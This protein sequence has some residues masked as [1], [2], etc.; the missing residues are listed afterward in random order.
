VGGVTALLHR[1]ERAILLLQDLPLPGTG[2]LKLRAGEQQQRTL[3]GAHKG[4]IE[5]VV[6]IKDHHK[7]L[8]TAGN[9][10][11]AQ[12]GPE[13]PEA[14]GDKSKQPDHAGGNKHGIKR[15]LEADRITQTAGVVGGLAERA[16]R[17][18]GSRQ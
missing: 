5:T 7:R 17:T 8:T 9:N 4:G 1:P 16:N 3:A 6:A 13:Q 10:S 11:G 2:L 15:T 12:N 14:G 18:V